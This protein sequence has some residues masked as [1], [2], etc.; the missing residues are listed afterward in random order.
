VIH[1]GD[2]GRR[3]IAASAVSVTVALL[4]LWRPE[5]LSIL[6]HD[7]GCWLQADS[8][9]A[10]SVN[11]GALGGNSFDDILG[12]QYRRHPATTFALGAAAKVPLVTND[13]HL[14]VHRN[15]VGFDVL[16]PR[17]LLTRAG[18]TPS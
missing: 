7:R 14:L 3:I 4:A 18:E 6:P 5:L 11:K 13:R 12:G 17:A 10:A 16:T 1:I 15:L 2:A 8:D 9:G